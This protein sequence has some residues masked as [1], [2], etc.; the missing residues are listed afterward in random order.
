MDPVLQGLIDR[1]AIVE[2]IHA[3]CRGV[4][5]IDEALLATVFTDDC[6][7][8]Y[9]PGL[10]GATHG[11][12]AVVARLAAGLPRFA[13]TA[14]RVSNIS[15][16]FVEDGSA[17]GIAYVDAWHRYPD[18]RPDA[19]VRG[20]YHDRF[21][22]EDDWSLKRM[23]KR[24]VLTQTFAM[25]SHTADARAEELDPSNTL[26]HRMPVRRLEGEAIRDSILKVSGRLNPAMF[27]PASAPI[28]G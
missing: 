6:V 17:T 25:G 18:E 28:P 2:V 16:E 5:T 13:A 1:Q 12:A 9:G 24:L 3:Y 7:V 10:G 20:C 11:S 22:R 4:D 15:I 26:L 27:G 23:I 21:V 14:H 19:V 8:D